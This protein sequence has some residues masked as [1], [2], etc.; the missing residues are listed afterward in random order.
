MGLQVRGDLQPLY[1]LPRSLPERVKEVHQ[2][3]A[4][5]G[6][7]SQLGL[8]GRGRQRGENAPRQHEGPNEARA[9]QGEEAAYTPSGWDGTL[10]P[11]CGPTHLRNFLRGCHPQVSSLPGLRPSGRQQSG[12]SEAAEVRN[13]RPALSL[14]RRQP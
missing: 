4:V 14:P 5:W 11:S 8:K 9:S 12:D 1:L 13:Q 3:L 7:L 10:P 2:G 6:G